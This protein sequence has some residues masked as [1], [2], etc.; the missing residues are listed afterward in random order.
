MPKVNK[1]LEIIRQNHNTLEYLSQKNPDHIQWCIIIIYYMAFHY[2]QAYLAK[3]YN[4]HPDAHA[5]LKPIIS[6][7]PNLKP[8]YYKYCDLENDSRQARYYGKKFNISTMRCECLVWF[9]DIQELII[10]LLRLS[11]QYK[12]NL[13]NLFQMP[14]S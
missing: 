6:K 10:R 4:D 8:I 1:H 3:K 11:N 2:I 5:L 14:I 9:S 12:Y 13:H 7:D